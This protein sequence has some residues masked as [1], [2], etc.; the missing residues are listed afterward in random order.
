M[1]NP[2]MA[3]A[4][5]WSD[6]QFAEVCDEVLDALG[7]RAEDRSVARFIHGLQKD[8]IGPYKNICNRSIYL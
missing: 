2:A 3:L 6:P 5:E 8:I 1:V 4:A 7:C